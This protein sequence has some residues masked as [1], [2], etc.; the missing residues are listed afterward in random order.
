MKNPNSSIQPAPVTD[1]RVVRSR[2]ALRD[3]LLTLLE[4]KSLADITTRDITGTARVG[5][6][7]F[8]RHYPSKD[9][10]L[11]DLAADQVT[12]LVE[13]TLPIMDNDDSLGACSLLCAYVAE[14]RSLWKALLLGGAAASIR[15]ALL[16]ASRKSAETRARSHSWLPTDL[17]VVLVASAIVEL[18]TWWL[19][20]QEPLTVAQ[21]SKILDRAVLAPTLMEAD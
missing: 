19:S 3:A 20:Q 1:L 12:R 10:L 17:G 7:T 16:S 13:M 2:E 8:Y 15:E 14:H 6:A 5:Y 18:L 4:H 9:A 21:A 11:N